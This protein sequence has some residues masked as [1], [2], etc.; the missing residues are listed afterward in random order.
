[1]G[2]RKYMEKGELH[3]VRF[4]GLVVHLNYLKKGGDKIRVT[5]YDEFGRQTSF[6]I[7][8]NSVISGRDVSFTDNHTTVKIGK[9]RNTW[10]PARALRRLFSLGV[11][12]AQAQTFVEQ[13]AMV[14]HIHEY[15]AEH[16]TYLKPSQWLLGGGEE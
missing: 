4:G 2:S 16:M 15:M 7:Q 12:V 13:V 9:G 11:R 8:S 5:A 3:V 10:V 1:M 14:Q 6:Y